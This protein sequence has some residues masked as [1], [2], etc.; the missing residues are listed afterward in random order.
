MR[1][2]DDY[3]EDDEWVYEVRVDPYDIAYLCSTT[4]A[5][6]GLAV[7]RTKDEKSGTVQFWVPGS[8]RNDFEAFLGALAREVAMKISEPRR[9]RPSDFETHVWS[10]FENR[11]E[12]NP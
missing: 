10:D 12:T 4:E 2:W 11:E 9:H 7:V 8:C 3:P 1:R 6:E 5:Y